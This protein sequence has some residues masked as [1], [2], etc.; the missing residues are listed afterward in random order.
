[1]EFV[2][3]TIGCVQELNM[4]HPL[5]FAI[6]K[7]MMKMD[8]LGWELNGL[9]NEIAKTDYMIGVLM[10]SRMKTCIPAQMEYQQKI[11]EKRDRVFSHLQELEYK[12]FDLMRRKRPRKIVD[13][14]R[15]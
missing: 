1:M 3:Y 9:N 4:A 2:N 5:D 14:L 7:T 11:I 10:R 12:V 15:E 6:H 8:G 13:L